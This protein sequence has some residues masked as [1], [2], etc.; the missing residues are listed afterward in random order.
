[1]TSES[2]AGYSINVKGVKKMLAYKMQ[3]LL[4]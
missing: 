4:Q 3:I 1:M 2:G